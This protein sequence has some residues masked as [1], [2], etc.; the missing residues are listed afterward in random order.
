MTEECEEISITPGKKRHCDLQTGG[1]CMG[2]K[3]A[4]TLEQC[5]NLVLED[6]PHSAGSMAESLATV[7][8][9][10]GKLTILQNLV[11]SCKITKRRSFCPVGS[12]FM[13]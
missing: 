4:W 7:I 1:G 5:L 2:I 13:V 12:Y 8:T 9:R 10:K 3:Q 11:L 6:I